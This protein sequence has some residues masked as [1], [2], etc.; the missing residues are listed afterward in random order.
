[1]K[2]AAFE[3]RR[4]RRMQPTGPSKEATNVAFIG[5]L[6]EPPGVPNYRLLNGARGELPSYMTFVKFQIASNL[7][8]VNMDPE[9]LIFICIFYML[10]EEMVGIHPQRRRVM[11]LRLCQD[12]G[13]VNLTGLLRP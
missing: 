8:Q 3:V 12:H 4:L 10:L 11:Y 1:M 6:I 2:A 7:K 5:Y 9:L 13:Q